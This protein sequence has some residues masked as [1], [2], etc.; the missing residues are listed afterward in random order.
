[1]LEKVDMALLKGEAHVAWMKRLKTLADSGG[2]IAAAESIDDARKSFEGLSNGMI[3]ALMQFGIAP[4][5]TANV[6][7]CPMALGGKG[8]D[9][10]QSNGETENPYY[11]AKMFACGDLKE[12]IEAQE[13]ENKGATEDAHAG[14]QHGNDAH[15]QPKA[16][17]G[18]RGPNTSRMGRV[19]ARPKPDPHAR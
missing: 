7:H 17:K 9:W 8:A 13:T 5:T 16:T 3:A 14:H 12:S 10:L 15:T 1:M 19:A 11:G 2:S 6:F 18:T 4:N